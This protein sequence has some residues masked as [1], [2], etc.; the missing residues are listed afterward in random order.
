MWVMPFILA[1]ALVTGICFVSGCIL[2]VGFALW[3]QG[4]TSGDKISRYHLSW[5]LGL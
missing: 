3:C 5:N 4:V 2:S 1:N